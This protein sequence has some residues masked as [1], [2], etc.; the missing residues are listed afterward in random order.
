MIFWQTSECTFNTKFFSLKNGVID[1]SQ[2]IGSM[3]DLG[4]LSSLC[5]NFGSNN[6][7]LIWKEGW[8]ILVANQISQGLKMLLPFTNTCWVDFFLM[9]INFLK[10]SFISSPLSTSV[11]HIFSIVWYIFLSLLKLIWES[12]EVGS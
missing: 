11:L 12:F 3:Q 5:V 2:R 8:R 6:N 10:Y 4:I 9:N 1:L 7:C